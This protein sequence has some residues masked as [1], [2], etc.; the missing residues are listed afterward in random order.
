MTINIQKIDRIPKRDHDQLDVQAHSTFE[1]L[2][3]LGGQLEFPCIVQA[4]FRV[5]MR[6]EKGEQIPT[7]IER[8]VA[9]A[10]R[11]MAQDMNQA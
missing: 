7:D 10:I 5:S 4:T 1:S 9:V 11:T 8:R 3:F 6:V 2:P